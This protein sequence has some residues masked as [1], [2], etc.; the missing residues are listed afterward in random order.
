[1]VQRRLPK[2]KVTVGE[3]GNVICVKYEN[4]IRTARAETEERG[5]SIRPD[6]KYPRIRLRS[7]N[8]LLARRA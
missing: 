7:R 8:N 3:G 4:G 2:S 5:T 1:M 6:P